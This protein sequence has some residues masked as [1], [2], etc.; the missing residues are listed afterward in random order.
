MEKVSVVIPCYNTEKYLEECLLSVINQTYTNL[1]II[2][3]NDGS[4]D[5]SVEIM[6]NFQKKDKR[7]CIVHQ[8][9]QGLLHA[10]K[11]GVGAATGKYVVFVDADDYIFSDE[12]ENAVYV[13]EKYNA[14]LVKFRFQFIPEKRNVGL[15]FNTSCDM[16]FTKE[17]KK[18]FYREF[19]IGDHLNNVW[20]QIF[21]RSL[22]DDSADIFQRRTNLGEDVLQNCMLFQNASTIVTT[23]FIGYAYRFNP[24]SITKKKSITQSFHNLEDLKNNIRFLNEFLEKNEL[25]DVQNSYAKRML[26]KLIEE[27]QN[28]LLYTDIDR[29]TFI[30]E[31]AVFFENDEVND[32]VQKIDNV[33]IKR[34]KDVY[35]KFILKR[36]YGKIYSKRWIVHLEKI[37]KKVS[38]K[39]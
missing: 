16:I 20:S 19:L 3:V 15:Y 38:G 13:L 4:T 27:V 2:I 18:D 1:E 17:N 23:S 10:R 7:V 29:D 22:Y 35:L 24:E 32:L 11:S 21:K 12:I 30:K 28:L 31:L 36:D 6:E 26:Y 8:E 9:N 14:D 33:H 25:Y 39:K 34:S 37:I 5:H